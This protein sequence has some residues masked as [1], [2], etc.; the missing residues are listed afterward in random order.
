MKILKF[1]RKTF[2]VFIIKII[3]FVLGRALNG[4]SGFDKNVR[5]NILKFPRDFTI[6]LSLEGED[7]NLYLR[8]KGN[9]L[10]PIKKMI[11]AI[12]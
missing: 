3:F 11:I 1:K 5:D 8:K 4:V 10:K 6:K 7:I 9:R 2:K 12:L